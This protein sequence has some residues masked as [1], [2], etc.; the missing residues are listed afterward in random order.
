MWPTPNQVCL[1]T[2]RGRRTEWPNRE[3]RKKTNWPQLPW[4]RRRATSLQRQHHCRDQGSFQKN[5]Q[6]EMMSGDLQT[7]LSEAFRLK[8][9]SPWQK[10]CWNPS[11]TTTGSIL[12]KVSHPHASRIL[13]QSY[14]FLSLS[15]GMGESVK[16]SLGNGRVIIIQ[17]KKKKHSSAK[18][19]LN[20][21]L[22]SEKLIVIHFK[23]ETEGK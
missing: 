21:F 5:L 1:I 4:T 2:I 18:G 17:I 6:R 9:V 8:A 15:W 20:W 10:I 19:L 13:P 11:S 3:K 16:I 7:A 23:E 14:D 22:I 12:T